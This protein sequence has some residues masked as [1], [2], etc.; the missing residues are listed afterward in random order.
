MKYKIKYIIDEI[1]ASKDRVRDIKLQLIQENIDLTI[2]SDYPI[3]V[4]LNNSIV[5]LGSTKFYILGVETHVTS[6]FYTIQVKLLDEETNIEMKKHE[7][8]EIIRKAQIETMIG[9]KDRKYEY[10]KYSLNKLF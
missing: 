3:P 8:N 4:G 10:Q 9:K 5:F 1:K 2:T 7:T 6:E